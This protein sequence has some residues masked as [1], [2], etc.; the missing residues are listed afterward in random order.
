MAIYGTVD[1]FGSKI[2]TDLN[3]DEARAEKTRR[4]SLVDLKSV[5]P[6]GLP[7]PHLDVGCGVNY[8]K[9]HYPGA[10]TS[11]ADLDVE[12]Y[13]FKDSA[14]KTITSI[15]VLEH[16]Y[17]PLFH[18]TEVRRVL[19]PEGLLYLLTPNDSSLIYR[20]EHLL[21]RKYA[22]HFHQFTEFDLRQ[23]MARAG[24]EVV[25]LKSFRRG[26]TGTI[27]RVSKNLF[28]AVCRK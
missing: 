10:I 17:N 3:Y 9:R 8:T 7:S 26:G 5:F 19:H 13:D 28:S 11:E 12:R 22:S 27:A 6:S 24:L 21:G 1:Q 25:R 14:F 4:N 2:D 20:A 15:E 23:I 16:L 18:L